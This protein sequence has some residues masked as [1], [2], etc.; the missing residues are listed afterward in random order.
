MISRIRM[1]RLNALTITV[2]ALLLGL[3]ISNCAL[4][5]IGESKEPGSAG[6]SGKQPRLDVP[7]EPT[8]YE[9]AKEMLRMAGV[10]KDDLVYD[11]GCGDGRIV[12]MA[13]KERGARG[14]GVDI[15]PQR[16]KESVKNAKKAGVADKVRFFQQDLFKTDISKATVMM[17]YL[18]PDVN[19]RLRPRLLA[20]L[21]PGTRVVSHSHK[22]GD[23]K[24]DQVSEAG[25]HTLYAWVIP[26]NVTGTW[27]WLVPASSGGTRAVL[28]LS[29][30]YQEIKGSLT[31]DN[32]SVPVTN[33]VL[34]GRQLSFF[35]DSEI[36]GQK[37]TMKFDGQ[38]E[39]D[40]ALGMMEMSGGGAKK[41][42]PWKAVRDPET[43]TTIG[44]K[45]AP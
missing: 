20:N 11:L 24:A 13:A 40:T 45:E 12:I 8:T 23:W 5:S 7:Y 15:D 35:V 31:I 29:Q 26:A 19:L 6:V 21:K 28:Q 36:N 3:V 42:I 27:T 10:Q 38:V 30:K 18:W 44:V 16:I 17:L 25:G 22:M 39:N 14:V 34:S 41:N 4:Y 43:R 33:A 32:S 9:I 1:M 2:A 37:V